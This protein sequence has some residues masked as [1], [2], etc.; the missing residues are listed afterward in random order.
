MEAS[1]PSIVP[2]TKV[3]CQQITDWRFC[4]GELQICVGPLY[5]TKAKA[6]KIWA[7]DFI[8]CVHVQEGG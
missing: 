3:S 6:R 5:G 4:D 1:L 7:K 8:L 2:Q